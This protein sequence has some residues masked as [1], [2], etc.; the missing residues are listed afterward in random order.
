MGDRGK[1]QPSQLEKM[2]I[3]IEGDD[4][5]HKETEEEREQRILRIDNITNMNT[6]ARIGSDSQLE[7]VGGEEK[8]GD[9]SMDLERVPELKVKQ[10]SSI[11]KSSQVLES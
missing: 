11:Q 8:N 2:K 1:R 10:Q 9:S 6:P 4:F 7:N 5:I 3:V